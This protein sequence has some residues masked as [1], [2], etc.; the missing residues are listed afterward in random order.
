MQRLFRAISAQLLKTLHSQRV[1][2]A[3]LMTARLNTPA[4]EF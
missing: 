4:L 2:V 3:N 1:A